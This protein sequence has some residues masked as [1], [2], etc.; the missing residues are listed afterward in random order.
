MPIYSR[1]IAE[2]Q[3]KHS[4]R[5]CRESDLRMISHHRL[6]TMLSSRTD[7]DQVLELTRVPVGEELTGC[8]RVPRRSLLSL[9]TD[10]PATLVVRRNE[11]YLMTNLRVYNAFYMFSIQSP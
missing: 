2:P 6:N 7:H 3:E 8:N 10:P 5:D 1:P 4:P 9:S 11:W